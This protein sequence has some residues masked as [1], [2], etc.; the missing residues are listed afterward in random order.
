[1]KKLLFIV[2]K[3]Y[4]Q[5][6]ILIITFCCFCTTLYSAENGCRVLVGSSYRLFITPYGSDWI[7]TGV[8]DASGAV[9]GYREEVSATYG[10]IAI[11]GG[12]CTV[13]QQFINPGPPS[14]VDTRVY[15]T[16][17][18]GNVDPTNCPIDDYIPAIL[19]AIASIGFLQIRKIPIFNSENENIDHH[20]SL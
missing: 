15:R 20:R 2:P 1:M 7:T 8:V 11:S 9:G 5:L 6:I 12:A 17:V 16:G 10:C 14:F 19:I 3:V 4:C 18:L 13:Y